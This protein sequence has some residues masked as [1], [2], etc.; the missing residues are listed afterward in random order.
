MATHDYLTKL[1]NRVLLEDR[2]ENSILRAKRNEMKV[3][4]SILD[5]DGFKKI[6]DTY[7]HLV[8]DEVLKNMASRI[9][10]SLR[11]GD[12]V[13]RIGG[14]EFVIVLTNFKDKN[15]LSKIINRLINSNL[16]PLKINDISINPTFS[17]GVALYPDDGNNF[18]DLVKKADEAL[19]KAKN[20]GKNCFCYYD[21]TK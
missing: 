18:E 5:M 11:E 2:V 9:K 15:E 6:N 7:G 12:T 21:E 16:E 10:R 19:Y 20:I 14:D 3:A 13:S 8:G 1:P 4:I 17:I